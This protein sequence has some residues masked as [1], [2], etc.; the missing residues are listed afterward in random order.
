MTATTG[1]T[2]IREVIDAAKAA[3]LL[4]YSTG[5][6]CSRGHTAPRLVSTQNCTECNREQNAKYYDARP[7]YATARYRKNAKRVCAQKRARYA[8][9]PQ[10]ERDAAK[11]WNKLNLPRVLERNAR[12]RALEKRATPKWANKQEMIR[13]YEKAAEMGLTVDHVVPLKSPLVCG[14]HCEANLELIPANDN[15]RKG[16]RHWPDMP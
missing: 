6:P 4:H 12:R 11:R 15:F 2:K 9:N 8:I 10:K 16:N 3:G 14:L 7:G 5:R 13:A 1:Q